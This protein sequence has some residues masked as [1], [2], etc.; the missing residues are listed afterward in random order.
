MY[1]PIGFKNREHQ[2]FPFYFLMSLNFV[3]V[4]LLDYCGTKLLYRSFYTGI[5]IRKLLDNNTLG[6]ELVMSGVPEGSRI[7]YCSW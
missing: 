6:E 1:F 3:I 5:N 2:Y 4:S 7:N